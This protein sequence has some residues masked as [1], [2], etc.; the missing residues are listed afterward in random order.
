MKQ[1]CS[2]QRF[3]SADINEMKIDYVIRDL[4]GPKAWN[5]DAFY[6]LKEKHFV[7]RYITRNAWNVTEQYAI[8]KFSLMLP[9]KEFRG[10]PLKFNIVYILKTKNILPYIVEQK[11]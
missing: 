1:R 4:E 5:F 11:L 9:F 3:V 8:F 6:L 2:F 10:W 7:K